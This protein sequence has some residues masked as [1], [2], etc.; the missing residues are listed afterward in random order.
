MSYKYRSLE[1]YLIP[2]ATWDANR[3]EFLERAELVQASD[4]KMTPNSKS[5][6][7]VP[8]TSC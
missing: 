7:K 2:K 5:P 3:E 8:Q 6:S 1:D 4:C